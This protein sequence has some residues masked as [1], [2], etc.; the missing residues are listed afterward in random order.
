MQYFNYRSSSHQKNNIKHDFDKSEI[1]FKR[2]ISQKEINN[3][4]SKTPIKEINLNIKGDFK[5]Y[6]VTF[7]FNTL[8]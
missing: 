5:Q 1:N 3:I 7:F 2:K 8:N 6:F 4:K